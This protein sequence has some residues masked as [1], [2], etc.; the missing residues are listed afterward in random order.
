MSQPIR[1]IQ[2]FPPG[3]HLYF[4]LINQN[5]KI[6]KMEDKLKLVDYSF[7]TS[8]SEEEP[9]PKKRAVGIVKPVP[10][11]IPEQSEESQSETVHGFQQQSEQIEIPDEIPEVNEPLQQEQVIV[12]S[13]ESDSD[14][15]SIRTATTLGEFF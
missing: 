8:E 12:L 7:S 9:G 14:T 4:L 11:S 3:S 2:N 15:I 10:Q 13:S 6:F 5:L 1:F